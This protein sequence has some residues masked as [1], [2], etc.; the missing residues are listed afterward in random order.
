M[1]PK[2]IKPDQ[3]NTQN[4]KSIKLDERRETENNETVG[5]GRD[6]DETV[7]D[8]WRRSATESDG[9]EMESDSDGRRLEIVTSRESPWGES[10][11]RLEM[12]K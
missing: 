9:N 10:R 3:A 12:M 4:M 8:G 7:R 5:D 11:E 1:N 2:P 6:G